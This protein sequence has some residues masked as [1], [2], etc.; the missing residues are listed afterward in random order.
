MFSLFSF[1]CRAPGQ[2]LQ[3]LPRAGPIQYIECSQIWDMSRAD[4]A[5]LVFRGARPSREIARHSAQA[6]FVRGRC[7]PHSDT[8]VAA[9]LID[10]CSGA[11]L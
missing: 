7:L 1:V 9:L 2:T 6:E 10:A 5:D 11:N 4:K 8:A 3:R